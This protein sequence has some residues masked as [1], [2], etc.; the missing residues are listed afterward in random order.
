MP[1]IPKLVLILVLTLVVLAPF[2]VL[3]GRRGGRYRVLPGW[4]AA[5][6]W[7][8]VLIVALSRLTPAISFPLLGVV[9]FLGLSSTSPSR[10]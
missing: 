6:S 7:F 8:A 3:A 9:M 5:W 4:I 1:A 2:A 10:L